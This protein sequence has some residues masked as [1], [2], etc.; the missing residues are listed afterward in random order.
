[1]VMRERDPAEPAA[2]STSTATASTCAGSAGPGSITHA[3]IAPTIHVFVPVSVNG[4]G[5]S[6]RIAD[7]VVRVRAL[8]ADRA[9]TPA[10]PSETA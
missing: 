3:G 8:T 5:F 6:A 9:G 1:M 10:R 2:R 7:D 4:P